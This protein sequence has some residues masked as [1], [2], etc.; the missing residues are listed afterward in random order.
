[1]PGDVFFVE[2][3][4]GVADGDGGAGSAGGFAIRMS[5]GNE[6]V[7]EPA[8]FDEAN[9]GVRIA[10]EHRRAAL[11]ESDRMAEKKNVCGRGGFIQLGGFEREDLARRAVLDR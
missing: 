6:I 8:A 9:D 5:D 10:R 11:P 2:K 4:N 3:G 1:M 7:A